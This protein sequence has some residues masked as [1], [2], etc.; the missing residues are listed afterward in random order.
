[1]AGEKLCFCFD[2][3]GLLDPWTSK[4]KHSFLYAC[5]T[6]KGTFF[7]RGWIRGGSN[8]VGPLGLGSGLGSKPATLERIPRRVQT[9]WTDPEKDRGV[10]D[11]PRER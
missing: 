8:G 4:E 1:M 3:Q 11:R 10:T 6:A 7:R 5:Q 9:P 2:V